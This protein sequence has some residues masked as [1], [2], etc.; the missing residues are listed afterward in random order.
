[1][2]M[3]QCSKAA[4]ERFSSGLQRELEPSG[5]RVTLVRAGAMYEQGKTFNADPDALRR[6][7]KAAADVGI[8]LR[9]RAISHVSSA[10]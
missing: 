2:I 8:H 3:Y 9:E 1:M 10:T 4:L 6:F 5:I 7:H